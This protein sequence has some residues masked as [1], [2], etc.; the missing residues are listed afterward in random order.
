MRSIRVPRTNLFPDADKF[1]TQQR[2]QSS[3]AR[4]V[5]YRKFFRRAHDDNRD[6]KRF[7]GSPTF[8]AFIAEN[9]NIFSWHD[10]LEDLRDAKRGGRLP[11]RDN[12][13][14]PRC[15]VGIVIRRTNHSI[16]AVK[17]VERRDDKDKLL[18]LADRSAGMVH[19]SKLRR[20]AIYSSG[21]RFFMAWWPTSTTGAQKLIKDRYSVIPVRRLSAG[22][23]ANRRPRFKVGVGNSAEDALVSLVSSEYSGEQQPGVSR[24][25]SR[26]LE[27]SRSCYVS[28]IRNARQELERRAARQT[29]H[30]NW[31]ATHEAGKI[32]YIRPKA[33]DK[34]VFPKDPAKTAA[35]TEDPTDAGPTR[36]T[37]TTQ[38][39]TR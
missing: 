10:K 6:R 5:R 24:K 1:V 7:T 31:F 11:A 15:S 17:V 9:R 27:S 35:E 22:A 16:S 20:A 25:S 37:Q 19:R 3:S 13:H 28:P 29:V 26:T 2:R 39:A 33:D 32:W 36:R 30:Q 34:G 12:T 14:L 21:A 8:T 4:R 38:R 18:G 23:W